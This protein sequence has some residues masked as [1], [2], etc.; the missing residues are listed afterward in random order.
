MNIADLPLI[1]IQHVVFDLDGVL[2]D[3]LQS[4]EEAWTAVSTELSLGVPFASYKELIGLPFIDI[5]ERLGVPKKSWNLVSELYFGHVAHESVRFFEGTEDAIEALL[6]SGVAVSVFTSKPRYRASN[7]LKELARWKDLVLISPEDIQSGRGK[8]A[9][10][11]LLS[12]MG[13]R[14]I[15]PSETLYVGDMSPDLQCAR[16]AGVLY[17]HAL[18]G[19]GEPEAPSTP[20]INSISDLVRWTIRD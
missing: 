5:L 12:L 18:W 8:P 17:I 9:P 10:D 15:D 16:R 7:I 11:G 4:M 6:D 13:L 2:V 1:S 14:G 3:S 20:G 19:Y